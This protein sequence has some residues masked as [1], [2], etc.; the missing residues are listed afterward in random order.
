MSSQSV[1][2]SL[3]PFGATTPAHGLHTPA[4]DT[5]QRRSSIYSA[6]PST[7][8]G[9][10]SRMSFFTQVPA[11]AGVPVDPRRLREAGT[12]AQ[13]AHELLEYMTV[14]NFD[15]DMQMQLTQKSL[16]SPTQKEFNAMFKWLYNRID[17]A[18]RF[19]KSIDAEIPLLL[20]QLRYPFEKSITKSQIAAVGGN[21]WHTFLGLLHWIM[22]LAVMMD[23][24]ATGAYDEASM[25]ANAPVRE[26][27]IMFEFVSDA[28]RAWLNVP[29]DADDDV[30][31]QAVQ[32]CVDTMAQRFRELNKDMLEDVDMLEA[33][34]KALL[35]QIEEL[36]RNTEKGRKLDVGIQTVAGD[37]E[38]FEAWNGKVS[39]RIKSKSQKIGLL[40]EDIKKIEEEIA[41]SEKEREAYQDTLGRQG[42]TIQD[43]DRM[44]TERERLEKSREATNARLEE[45]R[46]R[47]QEKETE[48]SK[49]LDELDRLVEKYN[50]LC[51]KISLVPATAI[52]AKGFDY[53]LSL[54]TRPDSNFGASQLGA[55]SQS[56]TEADRLLRNSSSGYLPHQ[57]L[58]LDL[59]GT[60]KNNISALRKEVSER[61]TAALEE[62]MRNHDFLDNVREAMDDKQAEVEG[63]GHRIRAAEEEFDKTKEVTTAQ[64]MSLDT[65]IERMEKELS[66]LRAGMTESVQMMEQREINTNLE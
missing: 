53:E 8:P 51:Y 49:R 13:M 64:K 12:R 52:N 41:E 22:Q 11:P 65:Q 5:L 62:D 40:E 32:S 16:S 9:S 39:T 7:V 19:Q 20:K 42:I 63:L 37:I 10:Q 43:I 27:R 38:K 54:L 55:S 2:K 47:V 3:A 23:A 58:N 6:R 24:Y 29:E 25:E 44:S 50:S 56:Q 60:V 35:E 61:R 66:K 17:P 15:M 30:A 28:Y 48:A 36:E 59:K 26:D 45:S 18:Y 33:E 31:D 14:N 46:M 1:R 34:K 57:L 4:P 21:N